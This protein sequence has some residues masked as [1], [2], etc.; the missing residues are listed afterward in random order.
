MTLK[1]ATKSRIATGSMCKCPGVKWQISS[2]EEEESDVPRCHRVKCFCT[3]LNEVCPKS[4]QRARHIVYKNMAY[5]RTIEGLTDLAE[6]LNENAVWLGLIQHRPRHETSGKRAALMKVFGGTCKRIKVGATGESSSESGS[7][8]EGLGEASASEIDYVDLTGSS[9]GATDHPTSEFEGENRPLSDF[10][11]EERPPSY[12]SIRPPSD[13]GSIECP[14][15]FFGL[16]ERTVDDFE[17]LTALH[18]Q[19]IGA[20]ASTEEPKS[21]EEPEIDENEAVA[22]P[23]SPKIREVGHIAFPEPTSPKEDE[24]AEIASRKPPK[25]PRR[26]SMGCFG[27]KTRPTSDVEAEEIPFSNLGA[28]KP[29][30]SDAEGPEAL[31][32]PRT[33][34]LESAESPKSP[35]EGEVDAPKSIKASKTPKK[36]GRS[37]SLPAKKLDFPNERTARQYPFTNWLNTIRKHLTGNG[38]LKTAPGGP[39][40]GKIWSGEGLEVSEE[41]ISVEVAST[42]PKEGP[43]SAIPTAGTFK[44]TEERPAGKISTAGTSN[45]SKEPKI[46]TSKALLSQT[47][48]IKA[49]TST[50]EHPMDKTPSAEAPGSAS[51]PSSSKFALN[52]FWKNLPGKTAS[53]QR[54]GSKIATGLGGPSD[55]S[56]TALEPIK[57]PAS[58]PITKQHLASKIQ[59]LS[60]RSFNNMPSA[61]APLLKPRSISDTPDLRPRG[62]SSMDRRASEI[63]T[64]RPRDVSRKHRTTSTTRTGRE[65]GPSTFRCYLECCTFN[66]SH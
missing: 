13:Y 3:S 56:T 59:A 22:P 46:L 6:Q 42:S 60:K 2:D 10:E 23:N 16:I 27:T 29:P 20:I 33:S 45:S 57:E 49:F 1:T 24:I 30:A 58:T 54:T 34:A 61:M 44:S 41:E 19:E 25:K 37:K 48:P 5:L 36:Q 43:A 62:A 64:V 7:E 21:P 38:P 53:K 66:R 11:A 18:Q 26:K 65:S 39:R 17:G 15:S 51:K 9:P 50:E 52:A 28:N 47:L 8:W 32:Q 12:I 4:G 35:K 63:P 40:V 31:E 55:Q 14:A